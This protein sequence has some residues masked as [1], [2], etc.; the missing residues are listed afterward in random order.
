M[1]MVD[2][3]KKSGGFVQLLQVIET[4]GPKKREQFMKIIN[5]ETPRWGEAIMAKMLSFEKILSWKPEA[6]MEITAQ[7]NPLAFG[8]ALKSLSQEQFDQFA[9][10]LGPQER[11][12]F[13]QMYKEGTPNPNEISACVMKIINET[14]LLFASGTLKFDKIDPDLAIPD[15]IESKLEKGGS[16]TSP[17][18]SKTADDV[19]ASA[20]A[21]TGIQL[22]N[23]NEV[24]S[25]RRK[26]VELNAVVGALKKEN[27]LMKDKLDKIK[28]IA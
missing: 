28:K 22:G 10:K 25:L 3:Y 11:R 9:A 1:A 4:C 7:T 14:R 15:E 13:E 19:V 26:I 6:I 27:I 24:D 16:A 5:E 2:R 8:T 21:S 20:S 18:G 12:K 17:G 23:P